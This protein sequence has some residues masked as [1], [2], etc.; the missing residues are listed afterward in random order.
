MIQKLTLEHALLLE[1]LLRS[2]QVQLSEYSF[3]SLYLF[4]ERHDYH[5][6]FGKDVYIKGT[7]YDN[8][9]Y[10][11][12]TSLKGF[13]CLLEEHELHKTVDFLFPIPHEWLYLVPKGQWK[14]AAVSDDSDYIY[15]VL[16]LSRFSGRQLSKKRNLVKQFQAL[17]TAQ[18]Q[19]ISSKALELLDTWKGADIE[20]CKEA[21]MQYEALKLTGTMYFVEQKLAGFMLGQELTSDTFVLHF[22]KADTLYKGIYQYMYQAFSTSLVDRYYFVNMEQDLGLASLRQTKHSYQ[23]LTILPKL[24]LFHNV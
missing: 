1:P 13:E 11:M 9:T 5:V 18:E 23:P 16:Q 10:L 19:P 8:H 20:E 15:D 2:C 21:I 24:R 7:T 3:C 6:V 22:A 12:P 14:M 17:Y 4:R